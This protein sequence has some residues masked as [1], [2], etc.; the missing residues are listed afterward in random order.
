[1][2]EYPLANSRTHN[3]KLNFVYT[4]LLIFVIMGLFLPLSHCIFFPLV[5]HNV[6]DVVRCHTLCYMVR[7]IIYLFTI[8]LKK[9]RWQNI[10]YSDKCN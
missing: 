1:M 7:D 2:K 4:R 6:S 8:S 5:S 3:K 9:P 10:G